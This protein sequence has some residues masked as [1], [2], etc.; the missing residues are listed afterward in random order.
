MNV[1]G[2]DLSL[3]ATGMATAAGTEVLRAGDRRGCERLA[4][5]R[6]QVMRR[7]S[8]PDIPWDAM[9]VPPADLVVVEGYSY[10]SANQAHQVGELGGVIRVALHEAG[11]PFVDVAPAALKKYA[12]GNGG[13]GKAEVLAAAIR[14]LGY[15]GH[16]D[17]E[18]D[19]LWLRSM[20]L[21]WYRAGPGV[22][23]PKAQRAVLA[24]VDWPEMGERAA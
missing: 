19:A 2:L 14:R 22:G 4:W 24:K 8:P 5:I 21:D 13:A 11:I 18:A 9:P 10:A 20:A 17:N 7:A 15:S 1:V 23:L 6:D 16:D 12:T 3:T